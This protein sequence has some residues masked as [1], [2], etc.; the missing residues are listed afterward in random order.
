VTFEQGDGGEL[1]AGVDSV[2]NASITTCNPFTN[3]GCTGTD[4]CREDSSLKHFYCMPGGSSATVPVCGACT[5]TAG[6]E[7]GELCAGSGPGHV[8]CGAMCCT[9]ADCGPSGKCTTT[10]VPTPAGVG[11]CAPK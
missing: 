4:I 11:V 5:G 10:V 3:A 8:W 1:D 2:G 7:H 6:C 9:D